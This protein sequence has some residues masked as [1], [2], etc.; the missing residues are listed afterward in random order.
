MKS[1]ASPCAAPDCYEILGVSSAASQ[2]Q[3]KGAF[4]RLALVWHPE[5]NGNDTAGAEHF[6]VIRRAY[7]LL[8]NPGRGSRYDAAREFEGSPGAAPV[9][10]REG[11]EDAAAAI[12]SPPGYPQ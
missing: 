6:K 12:A 10:C 1:A 7:E 2:E 5:H 11:P 4:R 8:V 9:H 3:I